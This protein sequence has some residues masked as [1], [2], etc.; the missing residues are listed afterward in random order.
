MKTEPH[1]SADFESLE[2]DFRKTF[3]TGTALN[4]DAVLQETLRARFPG[5]AMSDVLTLAALNTI[6][7]MIEKITNPKSPR[8]FVDWR[9]MGDL[10]HDLPA[11]RV[12]RVI[13]VDGKPTD[14]YSVG[15]LT[16]RDYMRAR[17][18]DLRD[19]GERLI[20]AGE[21][22]T[23]AAEQYTE[24]ARVL[25]V[26]VERAEANGQDPETVRCQAPGA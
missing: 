17:G 9:A 12:P 2:K 24:Q 11:V 26:I 16:L 7:K 3:R 19:E 15:A 4:G 10:F 14:A 22:K 8:D 5:L 20:Q 6:Q 21:E 13:I 18:E 25:D 23:H 1:I